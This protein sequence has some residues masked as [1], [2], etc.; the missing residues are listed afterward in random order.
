MSDSI[1]LLFSASGD[2]RKVE[3]GVNFGVILVIPLSG[4][5]EW[6][7]QNEINFIGKRNVPAP[8]Y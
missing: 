3:K 7:D 1:L 8:T 2:V 4:A 6:S 5:T